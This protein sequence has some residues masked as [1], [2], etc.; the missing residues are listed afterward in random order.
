MN[1]VLSAIW[2]AGVIALGCGGFF[3][4]ILIFAAIASMGTFGQEIGRQQEGDFLPGR[5]QN[6]D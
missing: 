5:T 3:L 2:T 1:S 4:V 6:G